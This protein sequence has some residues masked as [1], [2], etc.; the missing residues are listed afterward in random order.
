V[1]F[2]ESAVEQYG[3]EGIPTR[4]IIDQEGV[5]RFK[6]IGF[7]GGEKMLTQMDLQLELLLESAASSSR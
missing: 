7:E 1:L 2:D 4:F 5:I 3:V 6:S